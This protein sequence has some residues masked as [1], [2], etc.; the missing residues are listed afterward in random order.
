MEL[1]VSIQFPASTCMSLKIHTCALCMCTVN[2]AVCS[3]DF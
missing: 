2:E 1:V 3:V